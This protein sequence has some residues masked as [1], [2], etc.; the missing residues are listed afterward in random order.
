MPYDAASRAAATRRPLRFVT[1][2]GGEVGL[3]MDFAPGASCSL[4]IS[5]AGAAGRALTER[6]SF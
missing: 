4:R 3:D 5:R 6:G 1:A 2:A